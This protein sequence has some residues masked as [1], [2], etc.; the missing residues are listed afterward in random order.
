MKTSLLAV[1][2]IAVLIG[3]K[4]GDRTPRRVHAPTCESSIVVPRSMFD[5]PQNDIEISR[6]N[7]AG[8][9]AGLTCVDR[10]PG[11]RLVDYL[12]PMR[13]AALGEDS[14]PD[15][16]CEA[17]SIDGRMAMLCPFKGALSML[18]VI[19]T[20]RRFTIITIAHGDEKG[21]NVQRMGRLIID[22]F[23]STEPRE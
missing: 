4:P 8:F 11:L 9:A 3:C 7:L 13:E 20:P 21:Q 2:A 5:F 17:A 15:G 6:V 23:R 1:A 18:A 16:D 10:E 22:S 12:E 19:Q 14:T